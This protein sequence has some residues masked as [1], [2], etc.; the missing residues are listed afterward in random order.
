MLEVHLFIQ[1]GQKHDSMVVF[2]ELSRFTDGVGI[3]R[4]QEIDEEIIDFII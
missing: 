4:P 1:F 2:I 3:L